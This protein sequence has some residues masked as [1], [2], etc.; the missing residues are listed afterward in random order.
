MGQISRSLMSLAV[1]FAIATPREGGDEPRQESPLQDKLIGSWRMVSAKYGGQEYR[2]PAGTTSIK[3][4]TQTQFMWAS[5]GEDGEV[6]RAA[7]G[8]Y[9]LK[10]G[11]YEELPRYGI[12]QDF[13]TIK[14]K[15][16]SFKCKIEGNKWHH[17]GKLDSGLTI[18]EVWERVERK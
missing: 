13:E 14:G 6:T 8:T 7:G 11:A 10:G 3:H 9:T 12:G 5:Y 1:I 2:F 18:E 16:Q 17:D 15:V 4:I